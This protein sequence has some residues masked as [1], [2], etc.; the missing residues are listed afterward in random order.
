MFADATLLIGLLLLAF[1]LSFALIALLLLYSKVYGRVEKMDR[2][3][4][5]LLKQKQEFD[6]KAAELA[7]AQAQELIKEASVKAQAIIRQAETVSTDVRRRLDSQL[8]QLPK[9]QQDIY[10]DVFKQV[11]EEAIQVLHQVS[12]EMKVYADREVKAFGAALQERTAATQEE[13][14]KA[15]EQSYERM[16]AEILAYKQKR[17]TMIDQSIH[18]VIREVTEEVLGKAI[19]TEQH[20]E[21]VIK[22]LEDAKSAH[23]V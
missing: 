4:A 21:I 22:A 19:H 15:I 23:V 7:S 3:Q 11:G 18:Q 8:E 20:Q 13:A 16:E 17:L 2:F 5:D 14:K 9:A 1:L 10:R 6:A 12:D